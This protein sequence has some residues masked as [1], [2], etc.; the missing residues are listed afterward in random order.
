MKIPLR[1]TVYFYSIRIFLLKGHLYKCTANTNNELY[2]S[3]MA[4]STNSPDHSPKEPQYLR[5][6]QEMPISELDTNN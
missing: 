6:V 3:T 2:S 4:T 1:L 5:L